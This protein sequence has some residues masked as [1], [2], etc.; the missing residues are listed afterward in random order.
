MD[1]RDHSRVRG[2]HTFG[3]IGVEP[4]VRVPVEMTARVGVDGSGSGR[5]RFVWA[6]VAIR[7]RDLLPSN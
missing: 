1:A 5:G 6:R 3:Q 4:S 7:D 2:T